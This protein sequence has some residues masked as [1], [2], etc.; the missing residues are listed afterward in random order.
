[1]DAQNRAIDEPT[2]RETAGAEQTRGTFVAVEGI[3]G[4]GTTT[5]VEALDDELDVVATAEPAE[6]HWTGEAARRAINDQ[7]AHPMTDLMFFLGDRAYHI[8]NTIEPALHEGKTVVTDRYWLSTYAYQQE[9][10]DGVV[11]DPVAFIARSMS[12]WVLEPDLTILLDL[13]VEV[14]TERSAG[15]DK[16][17]VSEFQ[18]TVRDNY[19]DIAEQDESVLVVDATE[20]EEVVVETVADLLELHQ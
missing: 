18:R 1:M 3:D 7:D 14:A 9:N 19:L 6:Q 2:P 16:Y 17:E 10:L 4:S 20:P 12:E 11:R 8:E 15:E 5:V 13:P